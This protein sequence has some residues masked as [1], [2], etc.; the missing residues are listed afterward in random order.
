MTRI[1]PF[2]G[3][4]PQR[5]DMARDWDDWANAEAFIRF[6]RPYLNP[7]IGVLREERRYAVSHYAGNRRFFSPH[8][9]NGLESLEN[10]AANLILCGEVVSDFAAWGDPA[11]LR[12]PADGVNRVPHG[13]GSTSERGANFLMLDG[14]VRFLANKIDSELLARLATPQTK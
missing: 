13:F 1:L 6:V 3:V 10:R 14:S 9:P 8:R 7:D 12:D 4:Q 11:N 2:V 5:I